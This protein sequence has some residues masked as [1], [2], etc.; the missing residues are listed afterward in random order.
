MKMFSLGALLLLLFALPAQASDCERTAD[1]G[2]SMNQSAYSDS[3]AGGEY[4]SINWTFNANLASKRSLSERFRLENALKLA[5]GQNHGQYDGEDG[6]RAWA[7]PEKSSDRIYFE[8]LLKMTLGKAIDPYFALTAESQFYDLSVPE[9]PR[10]GNPILL[11]ESVGIGRTLME[12]EN[13]KL[14]TR[15][16]FALRQHL[17]NDVVDVATEET[18]R[19]TINDG[20]IEWVTDYEQ[21]WNEELKFVSKLRVFQ[22][23]FNSESEDLEELPVGGDY[24]KTADIAWEGTLT[25]SVAKYVQVNLFFELL[26]DKEVDLRGRFREV[27]GL[28]LTY[29]VF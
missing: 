27:M 25:A 6:A 17:S 19:N 2:L 16:G 3:W 29:Q 13:A 24:W 21:S 15:L 12:K 8:S 18:E 11:S 22:A 4:G 7:S 5:Y 23:V 14:F 10:Y 9:V 26:Y 1:L 20:G 28:G